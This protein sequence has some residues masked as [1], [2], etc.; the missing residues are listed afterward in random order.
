MIEIVVPGYR[1]FHVHHLVM[2]YNGTLAQDGYLLEGVRSRLEGLAEKL[3]LHVVTADT[4]GAARSHLTGIACELII[5]P[6]EEQASAK[7]AYIQKLGV[8]KVAAIGN[9][10]NDSLMLQA[11]VLGIA[12][13]QGE[14]MAFETCQAADLILPDI[15]RALDLF[16]YPKRLIATL[17]S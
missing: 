5:L 16:L 15:L 3:R 9:G 11:A 6:G 7:L 1:T 13:M 17:R 12:V 4:F 8:E 2:D 14:G 10:R